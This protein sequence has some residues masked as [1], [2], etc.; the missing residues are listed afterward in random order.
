MEYN[1]RS[2][3]LPAKKRVYGE[4]PVFIFH[5][6]DARNQLPD[7]PEYA[8]PG[9]RWQMC[10]RPLQQLFAR[11]FNEAL[12]DPNRRVTEGEWQSL[13]QQM[14]DCVISCP[15]DRA[16][17]LWTPDCRQLRCWHCKQELFIPPR[18]ALSGVGGRH[19]VLLT[20]GAQL[21]GRHVNP[22][23]DESAAAVAVGEVVQ[24][25]ANPSVWGLRNLTSSA[26]TAM[27]AD[28]AAKEIPSQ[29]AAPL[30]V[31]LK[32]QFGPSTGEIE[33]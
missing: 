18:L 22:H 13:F 12:P 25:P 30:T 6:S 9:K 32:L 28:G 33:A 2:W 23:A 19:Y 3:D 5:P 15:H 4:T 29:R 27:F 11:A 17:N 7:D 14:N 26:W 10:P 31:G 24:N 21:L 8:T 1:I 16:E 20:R